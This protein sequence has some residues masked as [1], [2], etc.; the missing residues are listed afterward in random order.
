MKKIVLVLLLSFSFLSVSGQDEMVPVE[1]TASGG[2]FS[3]LSRTTFLNINDPSA[4]CSTDMMP[5]NCFLLYEITDDIL[6][7]SLIGIEETSQMILEIYDIISINGNR[8]TASPTFHSDSRTYETFDLI[9]DSAGY[10][11][12]RR[13]GSLEYVELYMGIWHE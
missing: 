2:K 13:I 1:I 10:Y 5:E 3:V 11:L 9:K 12:Q 8:I 6:R 4:P 7:L